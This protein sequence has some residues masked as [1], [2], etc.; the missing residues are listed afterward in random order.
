MDEHGQVLQRDPD[1]RRRAEERLRERETDRPQPTSEDEVS[2]AIHELRVH[3]IELEMQN[4][5]L[6]RARSEAEEIKEQ[7]LDLYDFAPVGYFTFDILGTILSTNITGAKL[8]GIERG[9]LVGRRFQ[10]FIDPCSRTAFSERVREIIETGA[11]RT[12]EVVLLEEG[13]APVYLQ[14]EGISAV[15][16]EG[17]GRQ[18]RAA[19]MDITERKRAEEELTAAKDLMEHQ[20]YLLQRALIPAKPPVIEGYSVASAYVPAFAGQEIGGDFLD[21][22]M[23]EHGKVGILIGDVSGKGIEATALAVTTRSTV[24]AFA[25]DSSCPGDALGHANAILTARQEDFE[26]FVTAFLVILDPARGDISYST[27]GHPPAIISRANG[28]TELMCSYYNAPL[29]IMSRSQFEQANSCLMP[30][31]KIILYT[32]GV[33]EARSPV[34]GFFGTEG[35]ERVLAAYG[36]ATPDELVLEILN[37]MRD[38]ADGNLRDDTAILVIGRDI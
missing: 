18:C 32:D 30:G 20:L 24:G 17:D 28:D 5:E 10:L 8:I 36:R 33:S 26:H 11:K 21:V 4:E 1:L 16:I 22:F 6:M 9:R 34:Y 38:W 23:T 12:F 35:V 31:D 13:K 3:Q 29:G 7:Y 19:A 15:P 25:Y 14:I 37:A 2:R 27:A